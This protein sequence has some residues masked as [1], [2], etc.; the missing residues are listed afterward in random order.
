MTKEQ[1]EKLEKYDNQKTKVL[2]YALY[3]KR[4]EYEIKQKFSKK[5]DENT[6]EDIMQELKNNLYIDDESY[7]KRAVNEFI[8]LNKLSIKEIKYKLYTKGLNNDLI[9][10]YVSNNYE[11]LYNFEVESAKKIAIRQLNEKDNEKAKIYLKKKGYTSDAINDAL[12]EL[13]DN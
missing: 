13:Q 3:K 12:E 4:T 1:L 7:I 6:L 5:I 10:T 11:K 9:D 2:K 8:A